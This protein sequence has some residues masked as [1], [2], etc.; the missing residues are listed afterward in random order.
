MWQAFLANDATDAIFEHQAVVSSNSS[1][2]KVAPMSTPTT[3]Y[4]ML[5]MLTVQG[6]SGVIIQHHTVSQAEPFIMDGVE[7]CLLFGRGLGNKGGWVCLSL[8]FHIDM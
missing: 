3:V 7:R 2:N 8:S 4:G 1:T 6:K 5:G